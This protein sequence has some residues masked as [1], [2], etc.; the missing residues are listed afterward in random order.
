MF[1]Q[2]KFASFRAGLGEAITGLLFTVI[3]VAVMGGT[4]AMMLERSV[5]FA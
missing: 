5:I 3:V 4:T 1:K 2:G